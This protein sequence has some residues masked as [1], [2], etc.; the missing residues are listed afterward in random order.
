MATYTQQAQFQDVGHGVA[1]LS[2]LTSIEFAAEW[3]DSAISVLCCGS[4][5]GPIQHSP[6]NGVDRGVARFSI[7]IS[8]VLDAEWPDSAFPFRSWWPRS[9][10]T[11]HSHFHRGGRGVAGPST[12]RPFPSTSRFGLHYFPL[13]HSPSPSHVSPRTA[14]PFT[15]RMPSRQTAESLFFYFSIQAHSNTWYLTDFYSV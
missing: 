11:Q 5:S 14:P 6:F 8:I 7:L 4:R 3:P 2:I 13:R 10:P 12:R 9:G 15:S 1:R